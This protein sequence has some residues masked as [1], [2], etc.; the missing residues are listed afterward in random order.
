M[1]WRQEK[2]GLLREVSSTKTDSLKNLTFLCELKM[3][4][5][6][7]CRWQAEPGRVEYSKMYCG[8]V[9]CGLLLARTDHNN[10][11]IATVLYFT[12]I[13]CHQSTNFNILY[14]TGGEPR[15]LN[16]YCDRIW[17]AQLRNRSYIPS[18]CKRG[19]SCTDVLQARSGVHA[20]TI[21]KV[22]TKISFHGVKM[23]EVRCLPCSS[24][25]CWYIERPDLYFGPVWQLRQT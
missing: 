24:I 15:Y 25:W 3:G 9:I 21:C 6:T 5:I 11:L 23:S 14:V 13:R 19:F 16:S 17:A 4:D 2:V 18:R 8:I 20:A 7:V 10:Y 12:N 22:G 1:R